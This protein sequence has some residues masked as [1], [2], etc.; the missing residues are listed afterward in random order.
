MVT[1]FFSIDLKGPDGQISNNRFGTEAVV[2]F[3]GTRAALAA[4]T[5]VAS[6]GATADAGIVWSVADGMG[7]VA[8]T[9]GTAGVA[10]YDDLLALFLRSEAP[11]ETY[12][13]T[14]ADVYTKDTPSVAFRA[15][16]A[17]SGPGGTEVSLKNL[18]PHTQ[19][20]VSATAHFIDDWAGETASLSNGGGG[21]SS[22]ARSDKREMEALMGTWGAI[23]VQTGSNPVEVV[24]EAASEV[25]FVAPADGTV[26]VLGAG[27][28]VA[29]TP[30]FYFSGNRVDILP[31]G[32]IYRTSMPSLGSITILPSKDGWAVVTTTTKADGTEIYAT[33]TH[34]TA[35]GALGA[36]EAW[37][38]GLGLTTDRVA[39]SGADLALRG[40]VGGSTYRTYLTLR[41]NASDEP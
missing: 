37:F 38:G 27:T 34:A 40:P 35:D 15:E 6:L 3:D 14:F 41:R 17:V 13:F 20:R 25:P 8:S 7:S 12:L 36:L 10:D 33:V 31:D 4:T 32:R 23:G 39:I 19:I 5:V 16:D 22:E 21:L 18:P 28:T 30:A 1:T 26:I 2:V 9:G 11:Q 29:R 24:V